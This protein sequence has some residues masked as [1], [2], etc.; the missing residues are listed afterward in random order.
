MKLSCIIFCLCPGLILAAIAGGATWQEEASQLATDEIRALV[1]SLKSSSFA[2]RQEATRRLVQGGASA[3]EPLREA[4]RSGDPETQMRAIT[5]IG[6]LALSEDRDCQQQAQ[7]VLAEL[8]EAPDPVVRQLAL[9]TTGR[10]GE[11]MQQRAIEILRG[12]GAEIQIEEYREG[13][14]RTRVFEIVVGP[15][16]RGNTE[17]YGLLAWLDGQAR[18]TLIG[19]QVTDEVIERVARMSS[20]YWLIIKRGRITNNAITTLAGIDS[21]RNLHLYYVDIDDRCMETMSTLKGLLQLRLFGTRIS[22]EK[23]LWAAK[24]M[25]STEVDWRN[26][27][28]LGIYFNDSDGP[29]VVS[30]VVKDSAADRAGFRIGDQ[31]VRFASGDVDNGRQFLRAVADYFPGDMVKA[32]VLRDNE[33]IEL[34]LVLGRF[35]DVEEFK[36]E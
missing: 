12:H 19:E 9:Q 16:F 2:E 30:N 4:I 24:V 6:S 26:G 17:D 22:R 14:R 34:E 11:A 29:C 31:V 7:Q 1:Q 15:D 32:G 3:I 25:T 23:G 28:F 35:P 5:V 33:E 8:S 21:L 10:L 36:Q 20:L 13:L 18:V 27:A